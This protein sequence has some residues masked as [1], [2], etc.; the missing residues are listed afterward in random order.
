MSRRDAIRELLQEVDE[1]LLNLAG[2]YEKAKSDFSI[3]SIPKV[4]VKSALEHLR[5]VLD[6]SAIDIYYF[7][8]KKDPPKIYFPYAVDER[9]FRDYVSRTYPKI[10]TV[11]NVIYKEIE[12]IQPHSLMENTLL[13]LCGFTNHNKHQNLTSQTKVARPASTSVGGL[14]KFGDGGG[15]VI[16]E[17]C[18]MGDLPMGKGMVVNLN[19]KMSDVEMLSQFNPRITI[20]IS[21]DAGDLKFKL[22]NTDHDALV[23][24]TQSRDLVTGFIDR[25][26]A[27]ID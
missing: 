21:R 18:F 9:R 1:I 22:E 13:D 5:S 12:S 25:L 2:V 20:A 24:L 16:F 17:N 11:N 23:F 10:E 19:G 26:Y 6:Y 3:E 15:Q 8:Y 7:V 27:I 4:K 14:V